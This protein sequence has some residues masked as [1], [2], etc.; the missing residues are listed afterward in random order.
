MV[1]IGGI[2]NRIHFVSAILASIFLAFQLIIISTNVIMRYFFR[3]GISWMEEISSNVL[4]TAFTF[5]SMA[6]GVKL[7]SHIHV[8][9]FPQRTPQWISAFL[10]KLKHLVLTAIGFVLVYYGILLILGIKGRIASVPILPAY[11]QFIIIPFAGLLI[12]FDSLM[13]LFGLEKEDHYLDQIFMNIGAR[14]DR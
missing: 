12:L 14:N 13:N 2:L 7:D 1:K 3:S 9:L 11:L 8:N 10:L 5:L 4:M 6:I